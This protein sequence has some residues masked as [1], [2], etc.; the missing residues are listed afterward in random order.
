MEK[1]GLIGGKGF[2][3][4]TAAGYLTRLLGYRRAAFA[5][6]LYQEVADAY[7]VTVEFLGDRRTKEKPLLAL[8]LKRCRDKD[9]VAV[10]LC[11]VAKVQGK[12]ERRSLQ[13][14]RWV[15]RELKKFRSPRWVLQL[16][17]TEYRRVACG[18]DTYWLDKVKDLI[19]ANPRDR[20][21]ITDVRFGNEANFIE[22]LGGVLIRVRRPALEA[23]EAASRAASGTAAHPS[24]TEL[25]NRAVPVELINEEGNPDSLF[26]Q[27]ANLLPQLKTAA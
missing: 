6:A 21:V 11:V 24:E 27:L 1:I 7:S 17:G 25:L 15:N 3:K 14:R 10:C 8:Q 20:F 9:F 5:D 12:S 13:N 4:D 19:E 23:L 16:W 22:A 2:G 18:L 26:D